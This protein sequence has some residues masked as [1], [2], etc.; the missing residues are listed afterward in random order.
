MFLILV[1]T[2][3]LS[4]SFGDTLKTQLSKPLF[5]LTSIDRRIGFLDISNSKILYFAHNKVY[6]YD[7]T[8]KKS[9]SQVFFSIDSDDQ[10]RLC[11]KRSMTPI[12]KLDDTALSSD[13][14]SFDDVIDSD[15]N[16]VTAS[17]RL[18]ISCYSNCSLGS[19]KAYQ[20]EKDETCRLTTFSFEKAEVKSKEL[21]ILNHRHLSSVQL[22]PKRTPGRDILLHALQIGD[23]D[24]PTGVLSW[25]LLSTKPQADI[26]IASQGQISTKIA[27]PEFLQLGDLKLHTSHEDG[28]LLISVLLDTALSTTTDPN[29]YFSILVAKISDPV[30]SKIFDGSCPMK[31]IGRC[32]IFKKVIGRAKHAVIGKTRI[33]I[34]VEK[35]N[36]E[37]LTDFCSVSLKEVITAYKCLNSGGGGCP[38]LFTAKNFEKSETLQNLKLSKIS[39]LTKADKEFFF[40]SGKD[41]VSGLESIHTLVIDSNYDDDNS[42]IHDLS[43]KISLPRSFEVQD[44]VLRPNIGS[45]LTTEN[46]VYILRSVFPTCRDASNCFECQAN[47]FGL[48]QTCSWDRKCLEASRADSENTP[49]IIRRCP[50]SIQRID[51]QVFYPDDFY[52]SVTIYGNSL[53][54]DGDV[55]CH[56][57][58]FHASRSLINHD[59][60][61]HNNP[62]EGKMFHLSPTG[63]F[64]E[65]HAVKFEVDEKFVK[66]AKSLSCSVYFKETAVPKFGLNYSAGR[67]TLPKIPVRE[68]V[69]LNF[70]PKALPLSTGSML[71]V[72]GEWTRTGIE[73]CYPELRLKQGNSESE[74]IT[75]YLSK[76]T[77]STIFFV[78]P[79]EKYDFKSSDTYDTQIYMELAD[80]I[81]KT[82]EKLKLS[83]GDPENVSIIQNKT[84]TRG[85]VAIVIEG[86]N[87]ASIPE[88]VMHVQF[89]GLAEALLRL[90][91]GNCTPKTDF[92]T[93][94]SWQR[95][96]CSVPPIPEATLV[97][98]RNISSATIS[99]M[100]N[101]TLQKF[102]CD[103]EELKTCG[104]H[105]DLL[106]KLGA[107]NK[108]EFAQLPSIDNIAE[109]NALKLSSS[110]DRFLNISFKNLDTNWIKLDLVKVYIGR[111]G[112]CKIFNFTNSSLT[113]K[114]PELI[115][116]QEA[117]HVFVGTEYAV[118]VGTFYYEKEISM[119]LLYVTIG[120]G[121]AFILIFLFISLVVYLHTR[122]RKQKFDTNMEPNQG[123]LTTY[124]LLAY[125]ENPIAALTLEERDQLAEFTDTEGM[126]TYAAQRIAPSLICNI[127][128]KPIGSGQFGQVYKG[129]LMYQSPEGTESWLDVA[130]KCVRKKEKLLDNKRIWQELISEGESM[131][132]FSHPNVLGMLGFS[133]IVTPEKTESEFCIVLPYMNSDSLRRYIRGHSSTLSND[134]LVNFSYQAA[135]GMRYLHEKG[136]LHQDLAARNCMLNIDDSTNE[137]ILK[138][139]DFGLSTKASSQQ[140]ATVLPVMWCAPELLLPRVRSR[141][142]TENVG[143]NCQPIWSKEADVWA[144]GILVWEIFHEARPPYIHLG[145]ISQKELEAQIVISMERPVI[146][147]HVELATIVE[148][149]ELCWQVKP[150]DRPN[151]E[152]ICE[153][154][155]KLVECIGD[156]RTQT[157]ENFTYNLEAWKGYQSTHHSEGHPRESAQYQNEIGE[158][159]L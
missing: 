21:P 16:D 7:P 5:T 125:P 46:H 131:T 122:K 3:V 127:Q 47:V 159:Q 133:Y 149:M 22:P 80:S 141:Q 156:Y 13:V 2:L 41:E 129:T 28:S 89:T 76:T 36:A 142:Q 48:S 69:P 106:K 49:D 35:F 54:L 152:E 99:L 67:L 30:S 51:R 31:R 38:T 147:Q 40:V 62:S 4:F 24:K 44:L 94:G 112:E 32:T 102:D 100:S 79:L 68:P 71:K 120:S 53:S 56:R 138:V 104:F 20:P 72:T 84:L 26:S 107:Q 145:Q 50:P 91:P 93:S 105:D 157:D 150:E 6:S 118:Q 121:G 15:G 37:E 146:G 52:N 70:E 117:I 8:F 90:D 66:E 12:Y 148:L 151:F 19:E 108:I 95:L 134:I 10:F 33:L 101:K 61:L 103:I 1:I 64:I 45:F 119:F 135:C 136:I 96:Y 144:Y 111:F 58:T 78:P 87:L 85:G 74:R 124:H 17:E 9:E 59:S 39:S 88:P 126:S 139:C 140:K 57:K 116:K 130:L 113:C 27:N 83:V 98:D 11:S 97:S 155:D 153:Q 55:I 154:L 14:T 81:I 60:T 42:V 132:D 65:G 92:E 75:K 23:D 73:P 86:K 114:A 29:I 63:S 158:S 143:P 18:F 43:S 115:P 110:K 109:P 82:F 34:G 128:S 137:I 25:F 123:S 77:N